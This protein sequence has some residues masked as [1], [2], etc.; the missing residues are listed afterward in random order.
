MDAT[1]KETV[2]RLMIAKQENERIRRKIEFETR[3]S[4][5]NVIASHSK[6]GAA[7]IIDVPDSHRRASQGSDGSP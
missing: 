3:T 7:T 6:L 5:L 4:F 1:V 2:A